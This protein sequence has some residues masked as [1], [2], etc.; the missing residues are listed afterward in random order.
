M[1]LVADLHVHTISSG[2]AYSTLEE[3]V[4]EAQRI[5]LEAI[6]MTDHGPAMP[7]SPHEWYFSNLKMVPETIN[8]IRVYRGIE[9]NIINKKGQL[10]LNDNDLA[11]LDIVI[12]AMHPLC[13]YDNQGEKDNTK[14]LEKALENPYINIIAHAGNPMY[15]VNV[16]KTVAMA[17][18]RRVLLEINNSSFTTSRK[19][20]RPKCLEFAKEIKR[21]NWKVVLT[22]DSH[23]SPMLGRFD[24]A[25]KLAE[26]AG[27]TEEQV[28]NTSLDKIEKYLLKR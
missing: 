12:A 16:K 7:G 5:G 23:I 22:T 6:A 18:E 15:P 11:K 27:L 14:V 13:G 2:H 21:Q 8:G 20:S 3:Y 28:V 9:A 1:K 19:G 24:E 17:K 4:A 26:E 25:I 10:D